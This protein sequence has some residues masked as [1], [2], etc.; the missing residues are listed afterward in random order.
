MFPTIYY[1]NTHKI[2]LSLES[3]NPS[4]H[5]STHMYLKCDYV[6]HVSQVSSTLSEIHSPT[7]MTRLSWRGCSSHYVYHVFRVF[8]KLLHIKLMSALSRR[9]HNMFTNCIRN[10]ERTPPQG[11]RFWGIQS[12][13]RGYLETI[14][15]EV[16]WCQ[17]CLAGFTLF[18]PIISGI[19]SILHPRVIVF[20][21]GDNDV[22]DGLYGL[23]QP[24]IHWCP[25]R[26]AALWWTQSLHTGSIRA[27]HAHTAHES[28]G[29]YILY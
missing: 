29:K 26:H 14:I 21:D 6:S 25:W 17:P 27:A 13:L 10:R 4:C 19:A 11:Y 22:G 2:K 1:F 7:P 18:S 20:E 12:I 28:L 3:A 9:F 16:W 8:V 15:S 23:V 24:S 5:Y